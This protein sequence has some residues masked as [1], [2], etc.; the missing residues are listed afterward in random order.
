M[1]T[2]WSTIYKKISIFLPILYTKLIWAL[3]KP[4]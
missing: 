1:V 3:S 4:K 2:Y